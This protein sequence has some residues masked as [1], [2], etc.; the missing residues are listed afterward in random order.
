LKADYSRRWKSARRKSGNVSSSLRSRKTEPESLPLWPTPTARDHRSVYAS[1]ATHDHNSRP[2]SEAA[3]LWATPKASEAGP[4]FAKLDRSMTGVALPAQVALW[5][6]PTVA[7]TEGSRLSRSGP[8]ADELLLRGQA[9]ELHSH[10]DPLPPTHGAKRSASGLTLNPL[11][12]E[13][14]MGW[15]P[16]WT[17][18]IAGNP[19]PCRG[20]S[21]AFGFSEMAW[22]RWRRRMRSELSRLAL[23]P[24]AP[25]QLSLF[26]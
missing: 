6:T 20:G 5:A 21:I 23:P 12:V 13:W 18:L 7:D 26:G 19:S 11:F 3:G 24:T 8:R 9:V 14:L 25:A 2:L 1:E 4:D 17:T 10:L 15:P 22:C 16:G